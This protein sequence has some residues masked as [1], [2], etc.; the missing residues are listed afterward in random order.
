MHAFGSGESMQH[1]QSPMTANVKPYDT[2]VF[3]WDNGDDIINDFQLGIDTI[4]IDT[5]PFPTQVAQH[6]PQQ[7]SS[8]FVETF[9]DLD[10]Q[11]VDANG[12]NISDSVI[13]F[14]AD[15]SVTGWASPA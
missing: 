6:I 9:S 5:S 15:N 13:Q 14:D 3:S 4:E 12:D 10:I 11:E 1:S 8:Q 7:A 2:F